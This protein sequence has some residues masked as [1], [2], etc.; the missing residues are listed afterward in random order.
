MSL[1][2][3]FSFIE[4]DDS[5]RHQNSFNRFKKRR[6]SVRFEENRRVRV[7]R[8]SREEPPVLVFNTDTTTPV[9]R[10][11]EDELRNEEMALQRER[12][13]RKEENK[14]RMRAI[15][16]EWIS[17]TF[18]EPMEWQYITDQWYADNYGWT[19]FRGHLVSS[20]SSYMENFESFKRRKLSDIRQTSVHN[21]ES[22]SA[23]P[24]GWPQIIITTPSQT[25]AN[26]SEPIP[27]EIDVIPP[28]TIPRLVTVPRGQSMD[29]RPENHLVNTVPR[30]QYKDNGV[31]VFGGT[32]TTKTNDIR[33][34]STSTRTV[35]RGQSKDNGVFVFSGTQT[36][37]QSKI[38]QWM[39]NRANE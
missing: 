4:F 7:S 5:L 24:R 39:P 6:K 2:R 38:E 37:N 17:E 21:N 35:P 34:G 27:M 29:M 15:R 10:Q 20:D 19:V 22:I 12:E 9:V 30:G 13:R 26:R 11:R 8:C 25:P 28:Q 31:F 23:V 1:K 14:R 36:T 3:K 33:T 16:Y 18:G 32:Q